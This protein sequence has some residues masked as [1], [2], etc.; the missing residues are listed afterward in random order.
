MM[1][2][3]HMT[4]RVWRFLPPCNARRSRR[5]W[6]TYVPPNAAWRL[7]C[8]Q[9]MTI[10]KKLSRMICLQLIPNSSRSTERCA[11]NMNPSVRRGLHSKTGGMR[12]SKSGVPRNENY[13]KPILLPR[14][15]QNAPRRLFLAIEN[16]T[17]CPPSPNLLRYSHRGAT[18]SVFWS[19]GTTCVPFYAKIQACSRVQAATP[20]RRDPRHALRLHTSLYRIDGYYMQETVHAVAM[21][22]FHLYS[23]TL[24]WAV[25][26]LR[27]TPRVPQSKRDAKYRLATGMLS[28]PTPHLQ[29]IGRLPAYPGNSVFLPLAKWPKSTVAHGRTK[30][31]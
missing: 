5:L 23:I 13:N 25:C 26:R 1:A 7:R 19:T 20:P 18:G 16:Q 12:A 27:V 14:H 24:R 30:W 9:E 6:R 28:R 29:T 2:P 21:Y 4:S 11:N 22:V 3:E 10:Q 8:T 15:P 31:R 17:A